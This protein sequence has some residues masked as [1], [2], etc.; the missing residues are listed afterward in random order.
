MLKDSIKRHRQ[1]LGLSQQALAQ[2]VGCRR[3]SIVHYEKGR[4]IPPLVTLQA[5]AKAFGI[6]LDDLVNAPE[7]EEEKAHA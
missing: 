2:R 4:V 7:R 6:S 1:T 5:L 3:I